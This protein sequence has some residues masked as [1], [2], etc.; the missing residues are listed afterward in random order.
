MVVE[1]DGAVFWMPQAILRSNCP[2][3][4]TYFPFDTQTCKLK[5][6]SWSYDGTQ[7]DLEFFQ[8]V[9]MM[10][11]TDY[12]SSTEWDIV[13]NY[14]NKTEFFYDC[15]PHQPFPDLTFYIKIKR[16]VAFYT[17]ILILPCALLSL[18]TLVIFW[19]P[20]ESPAKLVL[21]K[22]TWT[23]NACACTCIF[24]E[25]RSY[26]WEIFYWKY[27]IYVVIPYKHDIKM[28]M[29]SRARKDIYQP[30]KQILNVFF[31]Y[32][33]ECF[34]RILRPSIT[35]SRINSKS[36]WKCSIDRYIIKIMDK[37]WT[38]QKQIYSVD[39][40]NTVNKNNYKKPNNQVMH[41]QFE[42]CYFMCF[43]FNFISTQDC[44]CLLQ[45]LTSV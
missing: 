18:L 32:R 6:G 24:T 7:V 43:N 20:P 8:D 22:T 40:F 1:Y 36:C 23:F 31:V 26:D 10:S 16:K 27:V 34:C 15:C 19:V 9:H 44:R 25:Y 21:G 35:T 28:K 37:N 45:E 42:K 4:T 17:F 13:D 39:E 14:A 38:F 41:L 12:L 30:D 2:F 5:F 11:L 3:S 29:H 33:N